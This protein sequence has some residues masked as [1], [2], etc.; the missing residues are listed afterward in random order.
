MDVRYIG[1]SDIDKVKWNSCVHYATNGNVYGY[2]WF[3]D[4]VAKEWDA[5]VEGDYESVFPLVWR[6]N[7]LKVKELYQ[8]PLIRELGL[9]SV[10][11]LSKARL[12]HFLEAIPDEYKLVNVTLNEQ[13]PPLE[14]EKFQW[15]EQ[16]NHQLLLD[17]PYEKI[18]KHYSDRLKT[19][20]QTTEALGIKPASNPKPEVIADFYRKYAK[21]RKELT[22]NF[23]ALQR[24]MYNVLH[25]GKGFAT[26]VTDEKG[27]LCAVNFY[28]YS[29]H[30]IIS[31]VPVV[32]PKGREVYAMP[33]LIDMLI[34]THANNK[35]I[36]DF[37]ASEM[38]DWAAD[39]GSTANVFYHIKRDTRRFGLF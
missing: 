37:N 24:I 25:R 6:E 36:L 13:N 11:I 31:L 10:N 17:E 22:R 8:P 9:Y 19:A 15:Q 12:Q 34:R 23:H 30:K 32:S 16:T 5:L 7:F 28:I 29:H 21:D 1:Q 26:G 3:L 38:D 20:L 18:R 39:F 35:L 14:T 27:E 2:M 33:F 4:N